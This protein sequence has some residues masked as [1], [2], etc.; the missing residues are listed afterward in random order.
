[1]TTSIASFPRTCKPKDLQTMSP[2][3]EI[4]PSDALLPPTADVVIIGGGIIGASAAYALARK[5]YSVALLEKGMIAG[6][7]SSRNWGWCRQQNR[8][9]REIPLIKRSLEMWGT[10]DREVGADLGFRRTGLVY[11]TTN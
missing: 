8:D 11:V 10:L 9:P 5:G 4:V 3:V 2:P 6:E 7:Q 1:M